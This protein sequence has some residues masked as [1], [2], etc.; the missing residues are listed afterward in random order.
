[1][2]RLA[3]TGLA[4]VAAS[5]A[6]AEIA[7]RDD[8]GITVRLN[9]PAQRIVTLG[10]HLAELV[11]EAGA[12]ARIVGTVDH[13][14]FP[15]A[16]RAIP[17]IASSRQVDIERLIALKPDLL[18]V[19]WHGNPEPQLDPLRKLGIPIFHSEPRKLDD[20]PDTLVRFGKLFGTEPLAEGRATALRRQVE[21]LRARYGRRPTVKVFYQVWDKPLYTLNGLHIVSESIRLCGGENIFDG[22]TITAP[23]V[24]VEAVL[25]EN[26]EAIIAGGQSDREAPGLDMWKKI[27]AL[28]ATQRRNLFTVDA[29][30]VTRAGPRI[31]EGVQSLCERLEQARSRRPGKP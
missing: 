9:K 2:F 24:S 31:V 3:L 6:S 13:S 5:A 27:P 1:M 7:V 8:A 26:P 25:K 19:W 20:I 30:L 17:R 22:M 18:V 15:E 11:F 16:A 28:L 29:D 4:F 12:G 21:A 14:D 10:P 23:M